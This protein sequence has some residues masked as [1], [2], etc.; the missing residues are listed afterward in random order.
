MEVHGYTD[1]KEVDHKTPKMKKKGGRT[2][3]NTD[4]DDDFDDDVIGLVGAENP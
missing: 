4:G 3:V 2:A 1:H